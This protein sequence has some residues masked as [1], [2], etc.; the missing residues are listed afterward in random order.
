[1]MGL[2]ALVLGA[3]IVFAQQVTSALRAPEMRLEPPK[4]KCWIFTHQNKSGGSSVKRLLKMYL[5]RTIG[6]TRGLYDSDQWKWGEKYTQ[7]YLQEGYNI[8]WGGY[9]EGLRSYAADDCQWFTMFRQ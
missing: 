3:I 7:S 2:R 9:T 6:V 1:M 4:R 8:T 5:D